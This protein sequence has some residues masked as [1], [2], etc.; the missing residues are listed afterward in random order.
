MDKLVKHELSN[1]KEGTCS[2]W[3]VNDKSKI[4][5]N[6]RKTLEF[7]KLYGWGFFQSH[8]NRTIKKELFINDNGIL[9]INNEETAKKK[10]MNFLINTDEKEFFEGV[11]KH[12]TDNV[13]K[14]EVLNQWINMS[15]G[16]WKKI[17][18]SLDVYSEE[19]YEETTDINLFRD[20]KDS[21]HIR[22]KN[23]VVKITSM[24]NFVFTRSR[25][26]RM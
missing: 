25:K 9:R 21:A 17:L 24:T 4:S 1:F 26:F 6:S 22:F 16:Q 14:E 3:E 13:I 2:F 18:H 11:F 8:P 12:P 20:N 10:V 5:F 7:L 19:S 15:E 23:G